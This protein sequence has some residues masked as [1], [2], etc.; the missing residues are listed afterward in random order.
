MFFK[1]RNSVQLSHR[2]SLLATLKCVTVFTHVVLAVGAATVSYLSFFV[3]EWSFLEC[4]VLVSFFPKES[5]YCR[6]C[7]LIG[8]SRKLMASVF[9]LGCKQRAKYAAFVDGLFF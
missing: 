7:E 6:S 9:G 1:A 2:Q 8:C 4:H 5:H 3:C